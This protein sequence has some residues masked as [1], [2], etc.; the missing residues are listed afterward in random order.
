MRLMRYNLIDEMASH[1]RHA[2]K[3]KAVF[4]SLGAN[5]KKDNKTEVKG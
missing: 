1:Y 3:A 4:W 5:A 2:K